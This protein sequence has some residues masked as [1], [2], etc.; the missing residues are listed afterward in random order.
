MY[1]P[2]PALGGP[3]TLWGRQFG[4]KNTAILLR[5]KKIKEREEK[6]GEEN[7][8]KERGGG[9]KKEKVKEKIKKTKQK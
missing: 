2:R 9:G 4:K 8:A 7:E 1:S 6:K 3:V 5:L